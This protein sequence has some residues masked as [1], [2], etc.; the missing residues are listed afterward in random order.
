M[1]RSLPTLANTPLAKRAC[2]E[3]HLHTH[4]QQGDV[5]ENTLVQSLQHWSVTLTK[6]HA[7]GTRFQ[8]GTCQNMQVQ[9]AG[10]ASPTPQL[11]LRLLQLLSLPQGLCPLSFSL[12]SSF[13]LGRQLL[14][15]PGLK[16]ISLKT[17]TNK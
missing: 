9:T 10:K 17:P 1:S 4:I 14:F 7:Q 16:L 11:S 8:D 3:A 2:V 13:T 6:T 12:S 5:S 15:S